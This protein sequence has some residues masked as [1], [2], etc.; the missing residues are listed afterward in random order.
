[1]YLFL[2]TIFDAYCSD[3]DEVMTDV[4]ADI[5]DDMTIDMEAFEEIVGS[6]GKKKKKS[7]PTA[8]FLVFA[9]YF[10]SIECL[11]F[12]ELMA[13]FRWSS[14]FLNGHC[15]PRVFCFWVW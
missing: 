10:R 7:E 9:D 11:N 14:G 8:N 12:L 15:W 2:R 5:D 1:M 13:L 6:S 3:I 4:E